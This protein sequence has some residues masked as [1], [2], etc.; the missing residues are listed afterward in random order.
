M[1]LSLTP[2][3]FTLSFL[4]MAARTFPAHLLGPQTIVMKKRGVT[5]RMHNRRISMV[6]TPDGGYQL[7][8][9]KAL[10][11]GEAAELRAQGQ[12]DSMKD[13]ILR[14]RVRYTFV[15]LSAEAFEAAMLCYE[16]LKEKQQRKRA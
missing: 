6:V 12:R 11:P 7:H 10:E 16:Q 15:T 2:F 5:K 9:T 8:I 4:F 3:H 1:N 14:D 13:Y